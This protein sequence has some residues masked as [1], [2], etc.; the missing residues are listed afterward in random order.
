MLTQIILCE[1]CV[2]VSLHRRF[3][4]DID[5]EIFVSLTA[6]ASP[7]A[8]FFVI[9]SRKMNEVRTK[10]VVSLRP[11]TAA[12]KLVNYRLG[13]ASKSKEGVQRREFSEKGQQKPRPAVG[14]YKCNPEAS[15]LVIGKSYFLFIIFRLGC[16]PA[17]P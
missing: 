11:D 13:T 10:I 16:V 12:H 1:F 8:S 4:R 14:R 3:W 9:F 6:N 17:M 5:D 2:N 15:Y 7:K